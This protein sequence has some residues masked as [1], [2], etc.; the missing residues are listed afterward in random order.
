MNWTKGKQ[1]HSFPL[2]TFQHFACQQSW[3][4][5]PRNHCFV[6][7]WQICCAL[8][9]A[10]FEKLAIALVCTQSLFSSLFSQFFNIQMFN[11]NHKSSKFLLPQT[12]TSCPL[13]SV[14]QTEQTFSDFVQSKAIP[15][16]NF[17][18]FHV[19][20][21]LTV[22]F[23]IVLANPKHMSGLRVVEQVIAGH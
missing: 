6:R 15:V 7:L 3:L 21:M 23:A 19:T 5:L 9:S 2:L 1:N 8:T 11:R 10:S 20:L 22:Q 14:V 17:H 4:F 16:N 13:L 18:L 12:G